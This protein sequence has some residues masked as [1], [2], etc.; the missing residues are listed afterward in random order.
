MIF[1]HEVVDEAHRPDWLLDVTNDAWFGLSAGPYQHFAM[2]RVRSVEEGLP[3]AN[4]AN[5][6]ISGV[7]DPYGRVVAQLGLGKTG[8]LDS[9]LPQP[10]AA[11]TLFAR[12]ATC[13]SLS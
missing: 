6:G 8:F 10:I 3:L 11:D 5:N 12:S 13:R 4:A 2:M 9:D 7:I 1:P